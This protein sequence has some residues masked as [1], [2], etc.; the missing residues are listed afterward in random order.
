MFKRLL[1]PTDGSP[2]SE[3]TATLAI[4]LARQWRSELIVVAVA[5]P[6]LVLPPSEAALTIDVVGETAQMVET[7]RHNADKL[8]AAA[9]A[10][11]VPC[12]AVTILARSIH[13]ALLDAAHTHQCDLIVMASHGRHG[14][15]RLLVGSQTQKVMAEATMPVLMLRPAPPADLTGTALDPAT[16]AAMRTEANTRSST[17]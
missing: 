17:T 2:L 1:L 3:S 5:Q 14:L 12:Q 4:D 9:K 6:A 8:C 16:A 10:A 13:K 11:G 7:A 15:S